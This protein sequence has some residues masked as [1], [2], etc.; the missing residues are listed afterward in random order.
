MKN[1]KKLILVMLYPYLYMVVLTG[2][3]PR[4]DYPDYKQ[5]VPADFALVKE[6]KYA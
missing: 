5:I 1:N 2:F 3:P 6:G 4:V